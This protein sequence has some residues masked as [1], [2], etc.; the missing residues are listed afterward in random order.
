MWKRPAICMLSF[1]AS[2]RDPICDVPTRLI[3]FLLVIS[4]FSNFRLGCPLR[5]ASS[6]MAVC[7]TPPLFRIPFSREKIS[8]FALC[9]PDFPTSLI[10]FPV[11]R[12]LL[13]HATLYFV[14]G[15]YLRSNPGTSSCVGPAVRCFLCYLLSFFLLVRL[16]RFRTSSLG[17]SLYFTFAV[18]EDRLQCSWRPLMADAAL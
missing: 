15:V 13:D 4:L 6:K 16:D 8:L 17:S 11:S 2:P 5:A 9:A 18:K 3:T 10:L 7:S 14:V 12:F 1:E